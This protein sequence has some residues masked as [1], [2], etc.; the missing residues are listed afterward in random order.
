MCS[1]ITDRE[2]AY[3]VPRI[4]TIRV[5]SGCRM[6]QLIHHPGRHQASFVQFNI[7]SWVF[8]GLPVGLRNKSLGSL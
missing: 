5:N 7:S 2:H 4:S 8:T 3:S 6:L 1:P